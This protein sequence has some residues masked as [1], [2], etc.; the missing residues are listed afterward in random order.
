MRLLFSLRQAMSV[1]QLTF[2]EMKDE[3]QMAH[4]VLQPVK[5]PPLK[6]EDDNP[7]KKKVLIS[8]LILCS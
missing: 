1:S 2:G 3:L 8:R 4:L 7:G 6:G 5:L